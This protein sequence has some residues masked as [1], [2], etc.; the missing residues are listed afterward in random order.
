MENRSA[1]TTMPIEPDPDGNTP[2]ALEPQPAPNTVMDESLTHQ[3]DAATQN[4]LD[5]LFARECAASGTDD[6]GSW[7]TPSLLSLL[8]GDV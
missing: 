6:F 1:V 4:D 2:T 5:I 8:F 7:D 3:D